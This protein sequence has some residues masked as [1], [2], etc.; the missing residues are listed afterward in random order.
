MYVVY[1]VAMLSSVVVCAGLA[2]QMDRDTATGYSTLP[3]QD[4][5]D[6]FNAK[7]TRDGRQ[8]AGRPHS[9]VLFPVI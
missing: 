3:R 6:G 4:S 5:L 2:V 8:S 1:N 9:F 7:P